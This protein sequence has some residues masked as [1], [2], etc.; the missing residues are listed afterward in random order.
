[1]PKLIKY[2]N[3]MLSRKSFVISDLLSK[4]R[5]LPGSHIKNVHGVAIPVTIFGIDPTLKRK[6]FKALFDTMDMNEKER[7]AWKTKG[8]IPRWFDV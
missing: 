2:A 8:E 1:M 3:S 6:A 5:N 4:K 7:I